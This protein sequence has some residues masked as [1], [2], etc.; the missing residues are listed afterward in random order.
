MTQLNGEIP[1]NR[2]RCCLWLQMVF[3]C[4]NFRK[5]I[6]HFRCPLLKIFASFCIRTPIF[7]FQCFLDLFDALFAGFETIHP[8]F[9]NAR[10]TL[11]RLGTFDTQ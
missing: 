10:G 8:I 6:R 5:E 9:H 11:M 7:R 4:Y 3:R 2:S 1:P